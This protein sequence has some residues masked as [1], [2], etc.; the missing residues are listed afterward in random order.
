MLLSMKNC[1]WGCT[2]SIHI[3]KMALGMCYK[4]YYCNFQCYS[5]LFCISYTLDSLLEGWR[6][7]GAFNS[8]VS[9]CEPRS[10]MMKYVTSFLATS[11]KYLISISKKLQQIFGTFFCCTSDQNFWWW[12][13]PTQVPRAYSPFIARSWIFD[14][15]LWT[16]WCRDLYSFDLYN[17]D[18]RSCDYLCILY[19]TSADGDS[20]RLVNPESG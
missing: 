15:W 17:H 11:K 13:P 7:D 20:G 12:S 10:E 8:S 1:S 19:I 2:H 16:P 18:L 6:L 9:N 4:K 5:N 3:G 14:F